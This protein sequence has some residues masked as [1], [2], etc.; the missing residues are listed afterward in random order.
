MTLQAQDE[1]ALKASGILTSMKSGTTNS[2]VNMKHQKELAE[3]GEEVLKNIKKNGSVSPQKPFKDDEQAAPVVSHS[4]G[5]GALIQQPV[6][7][8]PDKPETTD[9]HS[10]IENAEPHGNYA[11][12]HSVIV[13]NIIGETCKADKV[14]GHAVNGSMSIEINWQILF[15]FFGFFMMLLLISI[16]KH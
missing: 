5:A 13:N 16:L 8:V 7:N 12:E 15:A 11:R 1:L 10:K 9:T 4:I 2:N 3:K 6:A 14:S